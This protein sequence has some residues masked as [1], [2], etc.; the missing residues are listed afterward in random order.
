MPFSMRNQ[1]IKDIP[2]GFTNK[3]TSKT[4]NIKRHY[5]RCVSL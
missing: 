1:K 3:P 2:K 4:L 5:C